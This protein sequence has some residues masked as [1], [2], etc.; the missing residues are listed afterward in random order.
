MRI[1]LTAAKAPHGT[2]VLL[3]HAS[4]LLQGLPV[5]ARQAVAVLRPV[6]PRAVGVTLLA[7]VG[8]LVAIETRGTHRDTAPLWGAKQGSGDAGGRLKLKAAFSHLFTRQEEVR[9][10]PVARVL[11]AAHAV[12]SAGSAAHVLFHAVR[13]GRTVF[14]AA[15]L[16]AD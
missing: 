14:V 4:S 6:A 8:V 2:D 12:V 3:G 5:L 9:L 16:K 7:V 13:L 11:V 10:A 15:V 1:R